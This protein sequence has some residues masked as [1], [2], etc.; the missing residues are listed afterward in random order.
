MER[1]RRWADEILNY[2][3]SVSSLCRDDFHTAAPNRGAASQAA[4]SRLIGTL[5]PVCGLPLCGAACQAAADWQSAYCRAG[6]QPVANLSHIEGSGWFFDP[7]NRDFVHFL[8]AA[9]AVRAAK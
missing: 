8:E 9:A 3:P 7:V 2:Y 4:A 5:R 6:C 1:A